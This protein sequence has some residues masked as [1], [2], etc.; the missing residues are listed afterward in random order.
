M[1]KLR[2]AAASA[3][4]IHYRAPDTCDSNWLRRN[5]QLFDSWK[6][7]IR[8]VLPG[9]FGAVKSLDENLS[10]HALSRR[11]L[12]PEYHAGPHLSFPVRSSGHA[13]CVV[14]ARWCGRMVLKA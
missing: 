13:G 3:A 6:N 2:N 9:L 4:F 8:F 1:V 10:G 7:Q 12:A 11:Y 14:W 5:G